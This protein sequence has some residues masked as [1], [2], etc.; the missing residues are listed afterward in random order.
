MEE[1][2]RRIFAIRSPLSEHTPAPF[3]RF[4]FFRFPSLS[5]EGKDF[6]VSFEKPEESRKFVAIRSSNE[7]ENDIRP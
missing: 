6:L 4:F 7:N 3:S 1:S 2:L 5:L